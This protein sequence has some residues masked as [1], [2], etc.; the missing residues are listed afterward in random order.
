MWPDYGRCPRGV[1]R[2]VVEPGVSRPVGAGGPDPNGTVDHVPHRQAME[3]DL[4]WL[5]CQGFET[6]WRPKTG[7]PGRGEERRSL[8]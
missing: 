8:V 2:G 4:H 6:P 1:V 5:G 3:G 7:E